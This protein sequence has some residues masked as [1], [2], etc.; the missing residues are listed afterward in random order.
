MKNQQKLTTWEW[1]ALVS[2]YN[3]A[4]GHAHQSLNISQK[5]II[6]SLPK[7][8]YISESTSQEKLQNEFEEYFFP[9]AGQKSYKKLRAPQYHYA[10]SVSIEAVAN[11]LRLS[12]K[13]LTL[14]HPTFDNLADIFRRHKIKLNAIDELDLTKYDKLKKIDTNALMIVC[15][16]NPTGQEL[17]KKQFMEIVDICKK[18]NII[19]IVDFSFRF[20][21]SFRSW[22]QYKILVSSGIDFIVLEDTGKTFPTL[23][24]K[25]GILLCSE[26]LYHSLNDITNDF[27]LNVS[28]FVFKMITEYIRAEKNPDQY[29]FEKTIIKNRNTLEGL[30]SNTPFVV[31]NNNSKISV[32]WIKLPNGMKASNLCKYLEEKG[33][34]VLPGNP[35]FWNDQNMGES[36]F[37]VALA[38]PTDFFDKAV[39][40]L[41]DECLDFSKK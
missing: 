4:D 13:S 21:S 17:N 9:K 12:N 5:K 41:V 33:I 11:F 34:F 18:K 20:Y 1:K 30:F 19:L 26:S 38:R 28:P 3:L 10:S 35:F 25:L 37:R 40:K 23:D 31:Q 27:L 16:N 8:F 22:D 6:S 14:I 36:Y 24:L 15:P 29:S 39:S 32:A 7:I 2:K